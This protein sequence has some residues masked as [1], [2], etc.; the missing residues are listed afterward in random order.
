[1][2]KI[3]QT[4]VVG[5]GALG[6]QS[7][8]HLRRRIDEVYD[9]L[10]AI[11][12]LALDMPQPGG[13]VTGGTAAVETNLGP[14]E[15][16]ELALDESL[17]AAP[18]VAQPYYPWLSDR[19]TQ[20]GPDWTS[21]RAAARVAF[22]AQV[23]ELSRALEFYL[24]QLSN[25]KT[26]D[27]MAEHGF[28]L[29][30]ERNEASLVVVA[31]LG[32]TVGSALLLD[33]TYL[34][35]HVCRR[36]GLEV[37]S[38]A[39]LFMPPFAPS[40]PAAE[41]CAYAA[42]KEL[43]A[44]MDGHAYECNYPGMPIASDVSPFNRGCYLIDMYNERNMAVRSQD[45]AA[46]LAGEWL[47]RVLLTPLKGRIDEFTIGRGGEIHIQDQIASYSSLG[48]AAYTLPAKRL[49]EWSANRL[50]GE[51]IIDHLLKTESMS[52][53][54][55]RL[56]DFFNKTHLRPD[57]LIENE[58]RLGRDRKPM[59]IP[60]DLLP[61]LKAVPYG[62]LIPALQS[63]AGSISRETLPGLKRQIAHNARRVDQ[64][65]TDAILQETA[66]ILREAPVGGLSLASQF[67]ER[68]RDEAVRFSQGLRRREAAY[69]ARNMQQVSFLSQL[70]QA[71][72]HAVA[73]SPL[74]RSW[75]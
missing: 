33:V 52:R 53:V 75:R 4:I 15:F 28:E 56:G 12:L 59:Q 39:L 20:L 11:Q 61:R 7:I 44:C 30:T 36:A 72:K 58:L 6:R 9:Q 62:H 69:Q 27:V 23:Q 25:S 51:L 40:D 54:T 46:L 57:D 5:L 3:E 55:V 64:D 73:A 31:G 32:D 60:P 45:E 37:A 50:V 2:I 10:P 1:M 67:S 66:A 63:T 24:L 42:L 17:V 48:L 16:M 43:N 34:L 26:R 47:F 68:L 70:G 65:A 21:T 41:A 29:S 74:I 49:I 38:T 8:E 22:H 19:V 18:E 14:T 13:L 35:H 71:L